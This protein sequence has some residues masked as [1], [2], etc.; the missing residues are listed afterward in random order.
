MKFACLLADL[1][2]FHSEI[3]MSP[4]LNCIVWMF[5]IWLGPTYKFSHESF[6]ANTLDFPNKNW[7]KQ[8]GIKIK[9]IA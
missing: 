6:W 5:N 2:Q 1:F 3:K 4:L 7:I 8:Y 9:K